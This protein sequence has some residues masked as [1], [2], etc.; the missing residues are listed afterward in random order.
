MDDKNQKVPEKVSIFSYISVLG[1]FVGCP[2][3]FSYL[4]D[5]WYFLSINQQLLFIDFSFA[6][7][8]LLILLL[9]TTIVSYFYYTL[10]DFSE[11][12]FFIFLGIILF[13][14][15]I[16]SIS[17]SEIG[18]I[19]SFILGYLV[20]V[21]MLF[22]IVNLIKLIPYKLINLQTRQKSKNKKELNYNQKQVLLI[23]LFIVF[24]GAISCLRGYVQ[25]QSRIG[26]KCTVDNQE[27][28][29][30]RMYSDYCV[31]TDFE[32]RQ[33]TIKIDPNNL[34][35][36]KVELD[37]PLSKNP[38]P[39][40]FTKEQIDFFIKG[41]CSKIYYLFKNLFLNRIFLL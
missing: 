18:L 24:L 40:I 16:F 12:N 3:I 28:L 27:Y 33:H 6:D 5:Y 29:L 41:Y 37:K 39:I 31:I 13:L 22:S 14:V 25:S 32:S 15:I 19:I 26:Y 36:E 11:K 34:E 21:I 35:F 23:S 38:I 1:V 8:K 30:V 7:M 17:F 4:C 2:N 10:L 9:F 20:F